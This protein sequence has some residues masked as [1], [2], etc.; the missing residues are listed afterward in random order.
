MHLFT[1]SAFFL[2][3]TLGLFAAAPNA[4]ANSKPKRVLSQEERTCVA[5]LCS[6]TCA[7]ALACAQG[8]RQGTFA[9]CS[10]K[11][12]S[13]IKKGLRKIRKAKAL[14]QCTEDIQKVAALS[15]PAGSGGKR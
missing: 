4:E 6:A 14:A 8:R 3:L 7:K 10:T 15:C 11:C 13:V 12:E 9:S 1:K 5:N 2:T